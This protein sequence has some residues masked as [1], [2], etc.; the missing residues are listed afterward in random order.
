MSKSELKVMLL[1]RLRL[2]LVLASAL[3]VAG[4]VLHLGQPGGY[5]TLGFALV[6]GYGVGSIVD[7]L[8]NAAMAG[9]RARASR[10]AEMSAQELAC[11]RLQAVGDRIAGE[12]GR[13]G[14]NHVSAALG[15]GRIETCTDP[16]CP[17]CAPADQH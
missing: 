4:T 8:S 9:V 15:L 11:R 17:N 1:D 10:P 7:D 5:F 13:R 3:A 6:L 14:A 16:G 12:R 2:L